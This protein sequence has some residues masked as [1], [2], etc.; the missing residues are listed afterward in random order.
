[1]LESGFNGD[2][3]NPLTR[4]AIRL[5]KLLGELA[6]ASVVFIPGGHNAN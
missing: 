6:A 1:M 2:Q 3:K 5:H 4:N